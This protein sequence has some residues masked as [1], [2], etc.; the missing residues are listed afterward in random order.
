MTGRA[1][2]RAALACESRK[3][4][5]AR[6]PLVTA[7]L[8]DVGIAALCAA[9]LLASGSSNPA[10]AA[11]LGPVVAQGG[12]TG[13]LAAANQILAAAG[14]LAFGVLLS[15]LFGREFSDGTLTGLFALPVRRATLA[16]AKLVVYAAWAVAVSV[17]LVVVLLGLGLATGLGDPGPAGWALL[18]RVAL[19]A[20]LTAGL[21]IPAGWAATLGRGLLP[22][23]ATIVALVVVSQIAVL[24]G[25]GGW[26]PLSAPGLWAAAAGAD[27]VGVARVSTLQLAL[28]LPVAGG[29]AALTV[30]AWSRLEL[31][32]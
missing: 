7:V 27:A 31:D 26:F 11:K 17:G 10:M 23:I 12:W 15:W 24:S 19:V 29:F 1:L 22:G 5:S 30:R 32:R 14:F 16:A 25:A 13:Y 2:W 28:V 18:G 3:L 21:A 20:L 8:L 9:F 6:V 4:R